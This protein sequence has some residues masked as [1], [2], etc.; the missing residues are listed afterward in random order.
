MSE[1]THQNVIAALLLFSTLPSY[2]FAA[3]EL[4]GQV[5]PTALPAANAACPGVPCFKF[6]CGCWV[7][8][9]LHGQTHGSAASCCSCRFCRLMLSVLQRWS[10][11][12]AAL[13]EE[14]RV[15]E[16]QAFEN[17]PHRLSASSSQSQAGCNQLDKYLP[18]VGLPALC[19]MTLFHGGG[20]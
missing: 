4:G 11:L 3:S 15:E 1:A 9:E 19:L 10:W 20:C 7:C 18:S 14:K 5:F 16:F 12:Q 13:M 8:W 17:L 2:F 6:L